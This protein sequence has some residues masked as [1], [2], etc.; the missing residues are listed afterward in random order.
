M[1]LPE[2]WNRYFWFLSIFNLWGAI[3]FAKYGSGEVQSWAHSYGNTE[4]PHSP[5]EVD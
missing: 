2:E 5:K 4:E 1:Q 3:I